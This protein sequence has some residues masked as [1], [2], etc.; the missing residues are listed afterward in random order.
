M[1]YKNQRPAAEGDHVITKSYN[2]NIVAGVA[3]DLRD[4]GSS[5]N[6][7]VAVLTPGGK[8]DLTCQDIRQMYHVED[9][10]EV[11]EEIQATPEVLEPAPA[12]APEVKPQT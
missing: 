12:P 1:H 5:C 11:L 2:G 9:A 3:Y 7:T 4:N 8:V 6:C 10:F